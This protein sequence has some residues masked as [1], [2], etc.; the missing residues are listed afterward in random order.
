M[1]AFTSAFAPL[2]SALEMLILENKSQNTIH[3]NIA[4]KIV[5]EKSID[6]ELT[7]IQF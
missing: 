7:L 6:V 5:C 2:A 1:M 3:K 4:R